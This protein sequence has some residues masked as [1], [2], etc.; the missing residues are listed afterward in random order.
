VDV[1]VERHGSGESYRLVSLDSGFAPEE[2]DIETI[3]AVANEPLVHRFLFRDRI[4]TRRYLA[5][6]AGEFL[7]WA[8]DGWSS[9]EHLIFF[10]RSP[11]GDI[12]ACVDVGRLDESREALIGYWASTYHRGVVT[13]AV[14]C[15]AGISKTVGYLKLMA[16]VEPE[17][18]R[19]QGVLRRAG[20]TRLG[21]VE[22]PITLFD[23][24]VG[25]TK[26]FL[27]FDRVL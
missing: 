23:R 9:G 7:Q 19:S 6:D 14:N 13:N 27:H 21:S 10:L 3:V 2:G 16:L 4:G 15:L 1:P 20:F 8:R 12:G 25:T 11:A 17:N 18:T 24:P 5:A 22:Q 26:R